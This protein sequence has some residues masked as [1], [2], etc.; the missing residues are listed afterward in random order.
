MKKLLIVSTLALVLSSCLKNKD[1]DGTQQCTYDAC[2]VKAPASEI[3]SVQDYLSANNLTATQHCSGLFYS[4]ESEGSGATPAACSYVSVKYVGK[5]TNGNIFDQT[6]GS[7]VATFY[8]SEVIRGWTNAVPL[9][10]AGGKIR[11]YIPPSLGYGSVD[12]KDSNGNVVIPANSI[13]IFD[14]ELLQVY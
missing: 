7:N 8:L 5:F 13:L 3:Q 14:V 10:K 1:D 9:I 12:R 11:L 4:I 2:V 6:T